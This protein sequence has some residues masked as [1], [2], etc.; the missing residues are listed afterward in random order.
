MSNTT[1]KRRRGRPPVAKSI[2]EKLENEGATPLADK[3]R[4]VAGLPPRPLTRDEDFIR[5]VKEQVV[6]SPVGFHANDLLEAEHWAQLARELPADSLNERYVAK[7]SG[8]R[9][10]VKL[11]GGNE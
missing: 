7:V 5:A 10:E 4:Q 3:V 8:D 6:T 9:V 11:V 1:N 2:V